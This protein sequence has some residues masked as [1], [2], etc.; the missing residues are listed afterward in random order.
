VYPALRP[1]TKANPK[2]Q[3]EKEK[4]MGVITFFP[5]QL[6]RIVN[7]SP[8]TANLTAQPYQTTIFFPKPPFC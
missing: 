7:F 1:K 5:Y 4:T 2:K 8:L 3:K 6:Q